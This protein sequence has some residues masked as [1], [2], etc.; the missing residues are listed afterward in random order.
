M[1]AVLQ[2]R[3]SNQIRFVC[4]L[5]IKVVNYAPS[6]CTLNISSSHAN[7]LFCVSKF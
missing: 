4:K 3:S 1:Q 6:S 7:C 2:L 5:D